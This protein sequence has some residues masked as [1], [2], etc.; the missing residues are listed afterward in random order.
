MT[1]RISAEVDAILPKR[2]MYQLCFPH[3]AFLSF[4][5]I[6]FHLCESIKNSYSKG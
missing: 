5:S 2:A 1:V 3:E 6:Y 4:T